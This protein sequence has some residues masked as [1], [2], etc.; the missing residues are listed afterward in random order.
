MSLALDGLEKEKDFGNDVASVSLPAG[1]YIEGGSVY[2]FVVGG[3]GIPVGF[4]GKDGR[5]YE[6]VIGGPSIP[7][8]DFRC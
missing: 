1:L 6:F 4:I 3:R 7:I 5:P 8:I 2:E